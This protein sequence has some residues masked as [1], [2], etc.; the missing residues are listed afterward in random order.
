MNQQIVHTIC[1]QKTVNWKYYFETPHEKFG[2]KNP[3]T[4][5]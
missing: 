5:E 1:E 2:E 4:T 3:D